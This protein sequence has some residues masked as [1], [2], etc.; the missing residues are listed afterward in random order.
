GYAAEAKGHDVS[1]YPIGP[2]IVALPFV[3]PQVVVMDRLDPDWERDGPRARAECWRMGKNASAALTALAAVA[4]LHLLQALGLG[5][6]ALPTALSV[7][8]GSGYWS[9]ASQAPWQHGPAALCL[10]LA[11]LLLL[12]ERPTRFRLVAAGLATALMVVCRPIDLVF[13]ATIGLW[14]LTHHRRPQRLWFFGPSGAVALGLVGFNLWYFETL[15]GGYAQIEAMHPWAHGVKGTWTG[16]PINGALGTLFSPSHGLLSFTPWVAFA[17][18][19]LPLAVSMPR[20]W[21]LPRWLLV[22]LAPYFVLLATYSCWWG[23]HSFGPRFW[24][25]AVPLFALPL[26]LG[27]DWAWRHCRLAL[28]LAMVAVTVS[29][30]VQG[31]GA[32][33]YPS[34]WHGVPFSADRHHER[35]WD[36]RDSELTRCL[37]E[38]PRPRAW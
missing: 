7:A 30:A 32:W 22:S 1:R 27:L 28:G 16:N 29:V 8:L 6:V 5:R 14:V 13:S 25:D 35:L 17:L 31:I 10:T 38:G 12:P 34:S 19:A 9:V 37:K 11:V 24:I 4:L 36:W 18:A 2:A 21:S 26:G 33:C 23:G 20:N 15:S 3:M